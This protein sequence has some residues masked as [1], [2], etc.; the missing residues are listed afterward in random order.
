MDAF[1]YC[2]RQSLILETIFNLK[3]M[4]RTMGR[5]ATR[6]TLTDVWFGTLLMENVTTINRMK[7]DNHKHTLFLVFIFSGM[8]NVR[9]RT[10]FVQSQQTQY[11]YSIT[12]PFIPSFTDHHFYLSACT[13]IDHSPP[14]QV[15]TWIRY[16]YYHGVEHFTIY[17]NAK[18]DFWISYLH[19]YIEKGLLNVVEYTYPHHKYLYEQAS[20]LISCNRRYRFLSDFV[21][22][23]DVDEY[24][25][26]KN[27]DWRLSDVVHLYDSQFPSVNAF[28]VYN[29]FHACRNYSYK[30]W[31]FTNNLLE[32]CPLRWKGVTRDGRWKQI[33]RPCRIPYV[34]VHHVSYAESLF[35]SPQLDMVM[36]HF[37]LGFHRKPSENYAVNPIVFE[38]MKHPM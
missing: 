2:E 15:S 17:L 18:P 27:P 7:E 1:T 22:Y 21:L 6:A 25:L 29:T 5:S 23:S 26:T 31:E 3:Y 36:L 33:V 34:Q 16:H 19:R 28:R 12:P 32:I 10:F 14:S 8:C 13:V 9:N 38:G 30:F 37:K 11:N 4:Y 35:I 20:A 24:M